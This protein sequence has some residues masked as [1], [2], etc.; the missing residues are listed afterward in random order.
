M[1]IPALTSD[2]LLP[3]G[4]HDCTLR[5][6]QERFGEFQT[7]DARCRLFERLARF[8]QEATASGLVAAV[9]VDGSFVTAKNCPNDIDLI[10]ILRP[11]HNFTADL[12]PREAV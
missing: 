3:E 5:E 12:R 8:V 10:V 9:I 2:G 11:G 4:V 7:T 1:P 6:L